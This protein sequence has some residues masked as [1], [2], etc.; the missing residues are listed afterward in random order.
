MII[1]CI[2]IVI[3]VIISSWLLNMISRSIITRSIMYISNI[4]IRP[5]H[6]VDEHGRQQA[7]ARLLWNDMIIDVL[8]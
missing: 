8:L 7:G 4:V 5:Q 3:V 1:S 2:P 6:E